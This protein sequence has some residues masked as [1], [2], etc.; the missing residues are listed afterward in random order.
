MGGPLT[1]EE[2][3]NATKH[4]ITHRSIK[5]FVETGTY[6]GDTTLMAS[7]HFD[8]VYTTEIVKN[9]YD[10]SANRA[11]EAQRTNI[12]FYLG[13]SIVLLRDIMPKVISG[14][15]FFI[16]AHQSGPDTSNNGKQLVPLLEELDV[17]LSYKLGPSLFIFDDVRFWI[18]KSQQAPDWSK[19]SCLEILT[20]F[21][22]RKYKI[23][24]FF[25]L[26]DRFY[27]LTI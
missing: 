6:K 11:K 13:D 4:S 2:I 14:A 12:H 1:Y 7:K 23:Q 26:N 27:V 21:M 19:I 15:V 17:I 5:N 9:L 3:T 22:N 18:G 20:K 8:Q 16:D 10:Y 25:E 24:T